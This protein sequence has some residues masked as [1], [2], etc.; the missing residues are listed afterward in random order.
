MSKQA[1]AIQELTATADLIA[2]V[3][4][5][6]LLILAVLEVH[7]REL[8]VWWQRLMLRLEA[9]RASFQRQNSPQLTR[10]WT[11]VLEAARGYS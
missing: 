10:L 3:V 6:G 1:E 5:K 9:W 8:R 7:Q 11:D 2:T 4:L